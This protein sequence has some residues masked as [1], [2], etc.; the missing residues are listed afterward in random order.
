MLQ[1]A[2]DQLQGVAGEVKDADEG[3]NRQGSHHKALS[4]QVLKV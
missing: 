2:G 3:H 4:L 1:R